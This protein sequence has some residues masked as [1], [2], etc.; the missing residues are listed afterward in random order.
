[1]KYLDQNLSCIEKITNQ[2]PQYILFVMEF[3]SKLNKK[4]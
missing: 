1:M 2:D 4:F 3:M